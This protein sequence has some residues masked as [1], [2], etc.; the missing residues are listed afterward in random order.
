MSYREMWNE[1]RQKIENDLKYHQDGAMQSIAE[2]IHG[3]RKCI[4]ILNYMKEIEDKY[5]K[6][7]KAQWG[8]L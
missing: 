8:E 2:S 7:E 4:E 3:E 1:L 5:E 6:I